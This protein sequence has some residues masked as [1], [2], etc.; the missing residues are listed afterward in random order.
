MKKQ[1]LNLIFLLIAIVMSSC[2]SN[3][4]FEQNQKL[5][6]E[7]WFSED[8]KSFS[9]EMMDTTSLFNFY[10]NVRNTK[11]YPF[12]NLYVFINSEFPSGE[13]AR[14]TVEL[15]LA[16]LSGK[17]MGKGIGNYKYNQFILRKGLRFV[18]TGTY[19][20]SIE[21]GMRT[22]SLQGIS[23]IGIRLE[24]EQQNN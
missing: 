20:F 22:D 3:R 5:D 16:E 7:K 14:D 10:L 1:Y 8:A 12:A 6:N 13:T 17:W 23:D 18:Q 4:N 19:T 15:Q 21:Q 9:F 2:D 24:Y 11:D